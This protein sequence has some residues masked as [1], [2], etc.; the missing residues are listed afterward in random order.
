MKIFGIFFISAIL[1]S[2]Y[3]WACQKM[4]TSN[5]NQAE[6]FDPYKFDGV[7]QADGYGQV[8]V[9]SDGGLTNYGVT[10]KICVA[11]PDGLTGI[12]FANRVAKSKDG[13]TIRVWADYDPYPFEYQ[14]LE[15]IASVC[16]GF[17]IDTPLGNFDA[18]ADYFST[19]YAFFDLYG[20][21]WKTRS[22]KARSQVTAETNEVE[23]FEIMKEAILPLADAHLGI[24]AEING[25]EISYDANP[26]ITEQALARKAERENLPINRVVGEFRMN[27]WFTGVQENLLGGE[28]VFGGNQRIQYGM[29]ADNIG[30]FAIVAMGGFLDGE[31]AT[32]PKEGE[33]LDKILDGAMEYFET[34]DAK[35]VILDLSMNSGGYDFVGLLL[36]DRFVTGETTAFSKIAYDSRNQKPFAY[37]LGTDKTKTRFN[38]NVYVMI[39]DLTVSAG[40]MV[41]LALRGLDHV[42][43]VGQK[44]RGALST[45]LSK[46]LPNGWSMSVSNEVYS[47]RQGKVWEGIGI[48]PNIEMTIFDPE[49]PSKGHVEAVKKIIGLIEKP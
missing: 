28:S 4:P 23:L 26:G 8:T 36:A 34:N 40:E 45:V 24:D 14:R 35:T 13:N 19:H 44:T 1:L 16:P 41:P 25:E 2:G 43:I 11:E 47:D 21:D 31:V 18:F 12:D 22:A 5:F 29:A 20:V 42:T 30:Y 32:M 15:S 38:G 10:E 37:K 9:F 49:D 48:P 3:L 17:A 46:Y 27:H 39:S 6:T 7:W 33:V